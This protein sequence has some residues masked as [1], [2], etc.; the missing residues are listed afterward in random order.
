MVSAIDFNTVR[1]AASLLFI[2]SSAAVWVV[3]YGQ[4]DRLAV[5]LWSLGGMAFGAAILPI[6]TGNVNVQSAEFVVLALVAVCGATFRL[7]ALRRDLGFPMQAARVLTL[8][9]L[10]S[11]TAFAL[12][13]WSHPSSVLLL[14]RG[15][16]AIL[17]GLAAWCAW[18]LAWR[19][20][21]RNG[22]LLAAFLA[23]GMLSYLILNAVLL[24]DW[25]AGLVVG[26]WDYIVAS[27]IAVVNGAYVNLAYV[28]LV[29]DRARVAETSARQAQNLELARRK[30][31]E[32]TSEVL[33]STLHQRDR[34]A[35]ERGHLLNVLAH[36][37]RQPLHNANAAL[38]A[39][40]Q[41]LPEAPTTFVR[42][43]MPTAQANP[44]LNLVGTDLAAERVRHAQQVL[45][46]M[47]SVLEN[48][49]AVSSLLTRQAALTLQE[50]EIDFLLDL[51]LGDLSQ[52]ERSRVVVHRA[53]GLHT[54]EVEPGLVR[55][56]LSNLLRNAFS[57]GG[58]GVT[59]NLR[60]EE[61]Q[62]PPAWLLSVCDNGLGMSPAQFSALLPKSSAETRGDAFDE[63]NGTTARRRGVG[64]FIVRRV[65][66]LHAGH[67]KLHAA[68]GQG[69]CASLVFP[70]PDDEPAAA[71]QALVKGA[72]NT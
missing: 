9:T 26:R 19:V 48:T 53:P 3:L 52:A 18:H 6:A 38:Q 14:F 25:E 56:A 33:R 54:V 2:L 67:L 20:P 15:A 4:H 61:Q 29:L 45:I 70:L 62:Q 23:L 66:A 31:A 51:A 12:A 44:G 35:T 39:A 27:V 22:Q 64:L 13:A 34:L 5:A 10:F 50:V 43:Q 8:A 36:E 55:L 49:L 59:V 69:V 1:L 71:V 60:I 68:T 42:P 17:L 24:T 58:A 63:T 40:R 28:G 37:I 41:A 11:A 65:M 7:L 46:D 47:Q 32:S 72:R 57:H 16:A 21:S 30:S